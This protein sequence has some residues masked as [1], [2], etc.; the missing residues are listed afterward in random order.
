VHGVALFSV[1]RDAPGDTSFTEGGSPN[2]LGLFGPPQDVFAAPAIQAIRRYHLTSMSIAAPLGKLFDKRL[3]L[4]HFHML[5]RD[6]NLN[7]LKQVAD[8]R[9][10]PGISDGPITGIPA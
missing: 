2:E 9:S 8:H 1:A 6:H 4:L 3:R 10:G 5:L 7:K